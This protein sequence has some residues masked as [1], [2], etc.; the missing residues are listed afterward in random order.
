MKTLVRAYRGKPT[1]DEMRERVIR[2]L[3]L[4]RHVV[5][6]I[7]IHLPP[8]VESEDLESVG[9]IGLMEAVHRFDPT[10]GTQFK[11]F[12]YEHIR[13]A[14]LGELRSRDVVSRQTRRKIRALQT[15]EAKL[16]SELGRRPRVTEIAK[17]LETTEKDVDN[18]L[19]AKRTQAVLSLDV[20]D[21]GGDGSSILSGLASSRSTDPG[22]VASKREDVQRLADAMAK[23][24]KAQQEVL[25]LYYQKGLL[26]R[27]IGD[28]LGVSESRVCQ[29]HARAVHEL[30]MML[31][32]P[33]G[34]S[35]A[36]KKK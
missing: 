10:R 5:R 27:E 30:E 29:I 23:L 17:E 14:V 33:L 22:D 32:S 19:V 35:R 34:N 24:P 3:P 13:G 21:P 31:G 25:V 8:H 7:S 15:A 6:R 2:Y 20:E 11:T 4:V 16:S 28:I 26:Q 18:I 36:K 12:A 9:V 1:P